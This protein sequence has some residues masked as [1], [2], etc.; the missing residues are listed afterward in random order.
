MFTEKA[1]VYF[2]L[3]S[4]LLALGLLLQDWQLAVL[5]LPIA[6]LFFLSNVWG[7]PEKISLELTRHVVPS[8]SF[9]D[10]KVKVQSLVKNTT[11]NPLSNVEIRELLPPAI[12]PEKGTNQINTSLGSL[13]SAGL[14]MELPSL[15][16]GQYQIGPLTVRVQDPFGLYLVEKTL[17]PETVAVMP[18]PEKIRI[19]QLRPRHLGPWPG[20]IPSKILGSGTEFYSLRG[21]VSGDDP[22]RINWKS[23]AKYNRLIINEMEA[24]RVTDV[25]L[26]LDTDVA[27][28]EASETDLFE[29]E[30]VAAASMARFLL[31]Q[32]NR[33]GLILQ[34]EERGVVPPS[35]GKRHERKIL[36]LLAA[37]KPGR[38]LLSTSYVVTVLA[39]LMLP[40]RS[41][42][43]MISPLLDSSIKDGV[44]QLA[45]EGYSILVLSPSPREPEAFASEAEE[46]AYRMLML[47]RSNTLLALEKIAT[48]V[49]WPAEVPLSARLSRV[50]RVRPPV[51]I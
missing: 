42:I 16:R 17:E 47:G 25:M 46:V 32:G 29:R 7:L 51:Q 5:V 27:F 24:E 38:A 26:V 14:T 50:K 39:R 19:A 35:F 36:L 8:E 4:L 37:A 3:A 22:K 6:S 30:V 21:Y 12:V 1:V 11:T 34:G 13:Q 9:G 18:R 2:L 49:Q 15:G 23:S 40:A 20:V 33:V 28:F 41:Q 31:T 48:V 45:M 10:E 44:R 43:V